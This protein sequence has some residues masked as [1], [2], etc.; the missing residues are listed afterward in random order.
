MPRHFAADNSEIRTAIGGC[1]LTGPFTIGCRF[2]RSS[3]GGNSLIGNHDSGGIAS[4][5]IEQEPS[6]VFDLVF[7]GVGVCTSVATVV[8]ADGVADI[9]IT[10]AAGFTTPRAHVRKAGVWN[11]ADMVGS[12]T[13]P[14]TQAGGTVRFGEWEDVDDFDGDLILAAE[15]QSV[16]TDLQVE[17]IAESLV[18]MLSLNPAGVWLFDQAAITQKVLDLTGNGANESAITGTTIPARSAPITYGGS[19]IDV[20]VASSAP[21]T[22][23]PETTIDSGPANP[24]TNT[25]PTFTF[26]SN[27]PGSTFELRVDG[28]SY[29][30]VTSPHTFGSPLSLASHTVDIR[31]KDPAGNYD[32]TPASH[33]WTITAPP[34]GLPEAIAAWKAAVLAGPEIHPAGASPRVWLASTDITGTIGLAGGQY[35]VV[36]ASRMSSRY[37]VASDPRLIESIQR[38]NVFVEQ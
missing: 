37:I 28:G 35:T 32:P 12:L 8:A 33:T 3:D 30:V 19:P 18:G 17:Y 1:N 36:L 14:T 5:S 23:P 20:Q 13:N 27:E 11:H 34:A 7:S 10:K 26:S 2:A 24:D 22:T 31:A 21:D 29:S 4:V 16:L 9:W 6:G 15:W 25:T 38:M